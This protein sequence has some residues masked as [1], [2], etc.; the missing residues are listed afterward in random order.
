MLKKIYYT[1]VDFFL[2][3]FGEYLSFRYKSIESYSLN[4]SS[5]SVIIIP[6]IKRKWSSL[7]PLIKK[8]FQNN[9]QIY[10]VPELGRNI[11]S[12]EKSARIIDEFIRS[13]SIQKALIVSH[14]K[15]G[16]IGKY[17]LA[18]HNQNG[19]IIGL[20]TIATPFSGSNIAMK[21][22]NK[23]YDEIKPGNIVLNELAEDK[24]INKKIISFIPAYDNMIPNRE[25]MF[26]DG[27]E[28]VEV[29]VYGH[30]KMLFDDYS[31]DLII[32]RIKQIFNTNK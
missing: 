10:V 29:N 8:I 28:N 17:Y 26:L 25:S 19:T 30:H 12:I 23:I 4:N 16:L 9:F 22:P 1:A 14:S 11:F 2:I 6:G 13:N 7:I 15:G 3:I 18:N 5:G 31:Q 27:G 24:S 20:I 21:M 32:E